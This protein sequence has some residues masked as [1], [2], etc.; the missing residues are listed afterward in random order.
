MTDNCNVN[1]VTMKDEAYALTETSYVYHIDP[2]SL[3]TLEEENLNSVLFGELS[4]A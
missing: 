2:Q 1:V 3:D 4:Y